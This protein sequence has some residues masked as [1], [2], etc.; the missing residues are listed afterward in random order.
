M[1]MTYFCAE[2]EIFINGRGKETTKPFPCFTKLS[3]VILIS[4]RRMPEPQIVLTHASRLAGSSTERRR[5]PKPEVWPD[6]RSYW[7]MT[8]LPYSA[9]QDG[10]LP[11]S[12]KNSTMVQPSLSEHC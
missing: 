1:P 12:A 7:V 5:L 4:L 3:N 8:M 2:W 11:M 9:L 10:R 6:A